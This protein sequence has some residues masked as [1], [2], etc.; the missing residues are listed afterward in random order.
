MQH[1]FYNYIALIVGVIAL[2]SN[3]A[4]G[5]TPTKDTAPRAITTLLGIPEHHVR[6]EKNAFL[7]NSFPNLVTLAVDPTTQTILNVT[8]IYNTNPLFTETMIPLIGFCLKIFAYNH[9]TIQKDSSTRP[10]QETILEIGVDTALTMVQKALEAT[11]TTNTLEQLS[12]TGPQSRMVKAHSVLMIITH[13]IYTLKFLKSMVDRGNFLKKCSMPKALISSRT[14]PKEM[15]GK[16]YFTFQSPAG[17]TAKN[18]EMLIKRCSEIIQ[19][20]LVLKN[21][22]SNASAEKQKETSRLQKAH[23]F[24]TSP[25]LQNIS[26]AQ[27]L[28]DI[29]YAPHI[30]ILEDDANLLP[31]EERKKLHG[32]MKEDAY[33]AISRINKYLT[34]LTQP[35]W[36]ISWEKVKNDIAPHI[37][38]EDILQDLK[39]PSIQSPLQQVLEGVLPLLLN[40]PE[41]RF[42]VD[43]LSGLLLE[44][45]K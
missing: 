25:F 20:A 8:R 12:D 34:P 22:R 42:G 6:L 5:F 10:F 3:V 45:K 19:K 4:H 9:T 39:H 24:L 38:S 15:I 27:I 11:I 41:K 44:N 23:T 2:Q 13:M 33:Y 18:S 1:T 26:V 7:K 35:L 30:F 37:F 16:K 28:C 17:Y 36:N 32:F 21:G 40:H 31:R 43:L 29:P 14:I